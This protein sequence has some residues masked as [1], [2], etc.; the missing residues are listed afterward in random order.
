MNTI[1]E[2]RCLR[3]DLSQTWYASVHKKELNELIEC[4]NSEIAYPGN[5]QA[6]AA[7]AVIIEAPSGTGKTVLVDRFC[8]YIVDAEAAPQQNQNQS[9]ETS[10]EKMTAL[11]CRGKFEELAAVSEPFAAIVQAVNQLI[12]QLVPPPGDDDV[13][14]SGESSTLWRERLQEGMGT[15]IASLEIIFPK[16][17][18]VFAARSTDS[19]LS[20]AASSSSAAEDMDSIHSTSASSSSKTKEDSFGSLEGADWRF[21]RFRFAFR[22]FFRI[23]STHIPLVFVLDDL[24]W[25]DPDSLQLIRTLLDDGRPNRKFMFVAAMRPMNQYPTLQAAFAGEHAVHATEP[26]FVRLGNLNVIDIAFLLV[27]LLE[28]NHGLLQPVQQDKQL[29]EGETGDRDDVA[30]VVDESTMAMA[31]AIYKKLAVIRL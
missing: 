30:V 11:V 2:E 27:D 5:Q 14:E 3:L 20:V 13:Q 1:D 29:Q 19:A 17:A 10:N 8:R 28:R 4:Y 15:E 21:E 31:E 6:T 16:L 25:A 24:H 23:V 12:C 18:E 22:S 7:V 26:R 9:G